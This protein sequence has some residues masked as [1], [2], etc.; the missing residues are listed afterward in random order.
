MLYILSCYY[1]EKKLIITPNL[2][3]I[4]QL[5]SDFISYGSDEKRIHKIYEGQIK[6]SDCN[7]HISTWQSLK[8]MPEEF[9][10]QYGVVIVNDCSSC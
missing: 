9:F 2:N 10:N 1:K 4:H 3:L 5:A 7:V 6:E 8:D